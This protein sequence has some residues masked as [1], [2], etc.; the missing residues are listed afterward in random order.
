M[1]F[2]VFLAVLLVL[3]PSGDASHTK[4]KHLDKMELLKEILIRYFFVK[5]KLFFYAGNLKVWG[6]LVFE[7]SVCMSVITPHLHSQCNILHFLN[8]DTVTKHEL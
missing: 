1:Q 7:L 5:G 4:L 2:A 8:G 3:M 6:H